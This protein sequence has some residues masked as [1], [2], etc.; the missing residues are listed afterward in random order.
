[1]KR[2]TAAAGVVALGVMGAVALSLP[3]QAANDPVGV[4]GTGDLTIHK[5]EQPTTSGGTHD[6]SEITSLPSGYVP[7]ENA[8]FTITPLDGYDLTKNQGWD[9]AKADAAALAAD[10]S[11]VASLV[12][13]G[14]MP[15]KMTD[16]FGEAPFLG[17]PIGVYL[18]EETTLPDG[19]VTPVAPFL[20]TVP[21]SKTDGTGWN[22]DVHVY[23][24]NS[25]AENPTKTVDTGNSYTVGQDITWT[26][27]APIP[28]FADKEA[29][30][31][32]VVTDT[33]DSR[34]TFKPG[35]L[36]KFTPAS[37][38]TA[39]V[40]TDPEDYSLVV[41]GQDLTW[42]F[43]EA[44]REAIQA[45]GPGIVTFDIITTVNGTGT[46]VNTAF[47][48]INDNTTETNKEPGGEVTPPSISFLPVKV[49]KVDADDDEL[50]LNGAKFNVYD[51][52]TLGT[53]LTFGVDDDIVDFIT[54]V[55]GS[56]TF[57]SLIAGKTYYLEEIE[58]PA[59]YRGLDARIPFI[60]VATPDPEGGPSDL[61][62]YPV[63]VE[64][65]LASGWDWAL[66]LT[67]GA[68]LMWF[69]IGGGALV[70]LAA[71]TML[72]A[73]KRKEQALVGAQL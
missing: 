61:L 68:G 10:P 42:T 17:L 1:M 73:R 54:V 14:A 62:T 31:K 66:P 55:D 35:G 48:N 63:T 47:V 9:D 43:S 11:Y 28:A 16:E 45:A 32:L 15:E 30:S 38:G 21:M 46:I 67:G 41:S 24:K 69:G 64:N 22:Y 65:V 50:F 12:K 5:Y 6:G 39:V 71:G 72:I 44:G 20:V 23:P 8:G 27:S 26:I 34:L 33:L 59:G 29:F 56:F 13:G 4:S 58:A 37:T 57:D 2:V 60:P 51:V 18:V 3:A 19:A 49:T 40:L 7:I 36:V 52:P 25:L 53:P 70:V